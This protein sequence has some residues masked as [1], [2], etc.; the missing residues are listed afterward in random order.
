MIIP[1]YVVWN[2]VNLLSLNNNNNNN[3]RSQVKSPL[4]KGNDA[5][6]FGCHYTFLNYVFCIHN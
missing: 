4:Q 5:V 1:A 2:S 6:N 3:N